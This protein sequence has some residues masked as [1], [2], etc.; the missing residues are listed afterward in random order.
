MLVLVYTVPAIHRKENDR[1][2]QKPAVEV[3]AP[4]SVSPCFNCGVNIS[5]KYDLSKDTSKDTYVEGQ[6]KSVIC[7]S[8]GVHGPGASTVLEAI[9]EWNRLYNLMQASKA[10]NALAGVSSPM[11]FAGWIKAMKDHAEEILKT[12]ASLENKKRIQDAWDAMSNATDKASESMGIFA[13]SFTYTLEE[14]EYKKLS[15]LHEGK[16]INIK[17]P[18]GWAGFKK[19][20]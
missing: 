14:G 20:E 15:A 19:D 2:A 17:I 9:K 12:K 8:C 18:G 7:K 1:M 16:I 6:M 4:V 10:Y 11:E 13:G 5:L 3:Q